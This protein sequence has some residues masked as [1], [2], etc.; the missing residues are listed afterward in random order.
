MMFVFLKLMALVNFNSRCPLTRDYKGSLA[1]LLP[2]PW[3]KV[4]S[5]GRGELYW[6]S[7]IPYR[8]EGRKLERNRL[9]Y[10]S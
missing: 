1:G 7:D 10:L 3:R 6:A 4:H 5:P 9:I 8:T 2:S